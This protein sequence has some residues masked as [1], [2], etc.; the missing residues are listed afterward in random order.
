MGGTELQRSKITRTLVLLALASFL[1]GCRAWRQMDTALME[2]ESNMALIERILVA[3]P[4]IHS[5]DVRRMNLQVNLNGRQYRSSATCKLIADSV[6]HLSITPI[7]GIEM[8]AVR[9]TPTDIVLI[10][11]TKNL[12]Y[13]MDF[14]TIQR[15][16]NPAI[17]F[18]MI[19]S[20][21]TNQPFVVGETSLQPH[22]F[23][24]RQVQNNIV[25]MTENHRFVQE[26][27]LNSSFR[28]EKVTINHMN[29]TGVFEALYADFQPHDTGLFPYSG[30]FNFTSGQYT[31]SLGVTMN[32][33]VFN[34]PVAI[35]VLT[36]T[37]LQ[38]GAIHQ[39][40]D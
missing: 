39:L 7:F 37:H 12:Y 9:I 36:L 23:R 11:R 4:K 25:M 16:L 34:L 8:F 26:T 1:W 30:N 3:T 18:S 28:A 33:V 19:Q 21:L 2:K 40:I 32:S 24:Q 13:Q 38:R 29:S 14:Q 10:D 20:V 6:I 35:P 27:T 22:M 17:N 5:M 31:L 15:Q